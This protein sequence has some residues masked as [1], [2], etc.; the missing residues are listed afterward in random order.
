MKKFTA[1]IFFFAFLLN[2]YADGIC[3][4]C[5]N[6]YYGNKCNNEHNFSTAEQRARDQAVANLA[7]AEAEKIR[8]EQRIMIQEQ[9]RKAKAAFEERIKTSEHICTCGQV[10]WYAS[11]TDAGEPPPPK[12]TPD[13]KNI[14]LGL[15]R[16]YGLGKVQVSDSSA[17]TSSGN[18]V[19]YYFFVCPEGHISKQKY[20]DK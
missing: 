14:V 2:A 4:I 7:T 19:T 12:T 18:P 17:N 11:N 3:P 1:A 20:T 6:S 10:M 9:K 13:S 15:K 16:Q 5:G 8:T